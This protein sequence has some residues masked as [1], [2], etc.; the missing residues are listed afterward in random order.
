M[1]WYWQLHKYAID[2]GVVVELLDLLK[3]FRF[4]DGL[5]VGFNL[6]VDIGLVSLLARD[7]QLRGNS[8]LFSGLHFHAHIGTCTISRCVASLHPART[9]ILPGSH[10]AMLEVLLVQSQAETTLYDDQRRLVARIG[11]LLLADRGVDLFAYT[12]G[13]GSAVDLLGRHGRTTAGERIGAM[14]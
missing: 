3:E 14:V 10:C 8:C 4:G 13:N 9:R 2:G 6:A 5:W 11:L 1:S 7:F 12:F